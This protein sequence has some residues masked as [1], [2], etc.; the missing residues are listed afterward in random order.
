MTPPPLF[1]QAALDRLS[2]P[3]ELDTA[4]TVTSPRSWLALAA[5]GLM[6]AAVLAWGFGGRLRVEVNADG[7]CVRGNPAHILP[8]AS[9]QITELLVREGAVV[10]RG[11][12]VARIQSASPSGGG[13][14]TSDVLSPS[15]G[16]VT[17]I[18]ARVGDLAVPGRALYSLE[19]GDPLEAVVFVHAREARQ[20]TA[21]APALVLPAV[22]DGAE[23]GYITGEVAAIGQVPASRDAMRAVL[24]DDRIVDRISAAGPVVA[25]RVRLAAEAANASGLH[26]TSS[27]GPATALPSGLPC[28]A[29]VTVA[30][31]RPI[32][33]VVPALQRSLDE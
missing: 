3:E 2:A 32:S 15:D 30:E 20:V 19:L 13:V 10:T 9:G 11:Q 5:A 7:T 33:L 18:E 17:A 23:Y 22:Y 12:T 24:D 26:W 14:V 8:P 28:T 6:F 25:V 16:R 1:R 29:R 21:G 4:M 31:R 27:R